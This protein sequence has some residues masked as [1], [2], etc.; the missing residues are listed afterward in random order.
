MKSLAAWIVTH[1]TGNLQ[2]HRR[3]IDER[4]NSRKFVVHCCI[5]SR[6]KVSRTRS[7]K[8]TFRNPGMRKRS[9]ILSIP[10]RFSRAR[11]FHPINKIFPRGFLVRNWAGLKHC[12][13]LRPFVRWIFR[14]HPEKKV[15]MFTQQSPSRKSG[16]SEAF[17]IEL[18]MESRL[19][20]MRK[21]RAQPRHPICK[22]R[23]F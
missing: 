20:T 8:S 14:E 17:L 23:E 19:Q 2:P 1:L 7:L 10:N 21:R 15:R 5:A 12:F 9:R 18:K 3:F 13:R 11:N 4:R 22:R 16:S 6:L